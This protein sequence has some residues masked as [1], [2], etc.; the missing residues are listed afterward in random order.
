MGLIEHAEYELKH[1]GFD[2]H[3]KKRRIESDED[4]ANSI[5]RAAFE[6]VKTFSKQ[7]HSGFSA[8]QVLE[9]FGRLVQWK[10]LNALTDNPDEWTDVSSQIG[11]TCYQSKRQPSC[12][13]FDLKS[14]YDSDDPDNN[15]YETDG[16]GELTG[17]GKLK[18]SKD[19]KYI[20]LKHQEERW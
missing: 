8:R 19:L 16:K 20:A 14:Y 13:S 10:A 12:F 7:G 18:P 11:F 6:L 17:Y 1:A 5:G 2:I 4:Y 3:K 9:I 15:I